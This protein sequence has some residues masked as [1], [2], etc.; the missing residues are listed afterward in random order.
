M[1]IEQ[2]NNNRSLFYRYIFPIIVVLTV[3]LIFGLIYVF[4]GMYKSNNTNNEESSY[5][6]LLSI[7]N[8]KIRKTKVI[9]HEEA[10][11]LTSFDFKDDKFYINGIGE[12]YVYDFAIDLSPKGFKDDYEAYQFVLENSYFGYTNTITRLNHSS[13]SELKMRYHNQNGKYSVGEL[14]LEK[15][16]YMTSIN[17]DKSISIINSEDYNLVITEGYTPKTILETSKLYGIYSL[18][19]NK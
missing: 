3:I 4:R 17:S 7:V 5:Q 16:G 8:D 2:E 12:S 13:S 15:R 9:D 1:R 19:I 18:I 6:N 14:G 10:T 11:Y